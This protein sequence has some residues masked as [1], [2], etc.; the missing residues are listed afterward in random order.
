M[1]DEVGSALTSIEPGG[2]GRVQT[3]GEIWTATATEPI[4]QGDAVRVDRGEGLLLTVAR[5]LERRASPSSAWRSATGRSQCMIRAGG[6][7]PCC[8]CPS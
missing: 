7:V 4:T 6:S 1:I 5:Q 2:I 8:F 3:H